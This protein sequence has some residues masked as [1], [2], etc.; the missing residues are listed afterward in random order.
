M[1]VVWS[2]GEKID[3]CGSLAAKGHSQPWGQVH[4]GWVQMEKW[5]APTLTD[6]AKEQG[7]GWGRSWKSQERGSGR[8]GG[9]VG[10]VQGRVEAGVFQ[11]GGWSR[12]CTNSSHMMKTDGFL[13]CGS[14]DVLGNLEKVGS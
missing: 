5:G 4:I 10:S 2:P 14:V 9:K 3:S 7:T 6:W 8:V 12:K 11:G 13:A 1:C